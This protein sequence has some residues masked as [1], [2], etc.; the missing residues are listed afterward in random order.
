M[1]IH[2]LAVRRVP[3]VPSPVLLEAYD[4]LRAHG[5]E[6]TDAICE[7][8]GTRT[9]LLEPEHDLYLLK[10]H[11]PLALSVAGVLD[12]GGARMINPY[13]ACVRT[14]NKI[15]VSRLLRAAGVPAPRTWVTGDGATLAGLADGRALIVKPYQGHRGAGVHVVRDP[16]AL[17]CAV[18]AAGCPVVVQEHVPGPGED[19]KVYVV[20][21]QVFAVRKPFSATSFAVPGRPV[22]VDP[23]VRA[24]ALRVGR[25]LGLE[26]FGLDVIESPGGPVVVDVNYFPGYKGVPD[27]G[28]L[29]G[30]HLAA[31]ARELEGAPLALAA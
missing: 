29:I 5:H 30:E 27:A 12:A 19:L 17:R 18:A 1:R 21:E 16:G 15:V 23:E 11:T 13:A 6:V 4:V 10:S 25:A 26:L 22:A 3:A 9:D 14:Q 8:V 2:V 24:V 31:R 28:A 7:E 20:G